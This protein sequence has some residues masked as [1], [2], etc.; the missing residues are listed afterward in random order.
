[1]CRSSAPEHGDAALRRGRRISRSCLGYT[2]RKGVVGM[3]KI[4]ELLRVLVELVRALAEL[5]RTVIELIRSF[6]RA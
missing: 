5:V 4:I 2:P 3:V 1:M 6:T